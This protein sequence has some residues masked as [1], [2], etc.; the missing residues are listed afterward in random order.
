MYSHS[1]QEL[2]FDIFRRIQRD[3]VW[4]TE[5]ERV[6]RRLKAALLPIAPFGVPAG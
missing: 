5:D 6:R 4:V 3:R 2:D 1:G